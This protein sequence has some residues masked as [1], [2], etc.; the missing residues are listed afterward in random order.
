M[1]TNAK[2]NRQPIKLIFNSRSAGSI[3]IRQLIN[4]LGHQIN[5]TAN[6]KIIIANDITK[7]SIGE[8]N[9]FLFEINGLITP[10]KVLVIEATQ[11]QVLISN[12]WLFKTNTVFD[13]ITQ[14]LQLSQNG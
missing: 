9:K 3:I 2:V 6:T 13:W 10:I 4:Q 1:Y 11:Y 7:T 8:I 14:K 5:H 12:D